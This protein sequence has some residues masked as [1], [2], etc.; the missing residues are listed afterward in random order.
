MSQE[1]AA[2]RPARRALWRDPAIQL[3]VAMLAGILFGIGAPAWA[4][5]RRV[6]GDLFILLVQMFVGLIIFCTVVHGVAAGRNAG[7]I[8]RVAITSIVY[9]E[10]VTTIALVLALVLV[11]V[12]APGAGLHVDPASLSM[13]G[14]E[15]YAASARHVT[16]E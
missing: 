16:L 4:G 11:N 3:L 2:L 6:L 1:G 14:V 9:F 15:T 5:Q 7:R 10:I 8:G 13:K 12:I